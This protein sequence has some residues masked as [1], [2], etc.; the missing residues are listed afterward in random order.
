MNGP[1]AGRR[2]WHAP[3]VCLGP[4]W[5]CYLST[6]FLCW[7][8]THGQRWGGCPRSHIGHQSLVATNN[9]NDVNRDKRWID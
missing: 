9:G 2:E 4:W 1:F 6:V 5:S 3:G 7:L 8:C